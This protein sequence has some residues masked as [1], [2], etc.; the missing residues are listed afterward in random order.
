M[1]AKV[2]IAVGVYNGENY[3]AELLD[4][5]LAQTCADWECILVNDGSTDGSE[6]I[7]RG[8]AAKDTRFSVLSQPNAG[9]GAARNAAMKAGSSPYLMFADQDDRLAPNAV[10]RALAAIESTG[11]DIV[12]FHSNRTFRQSIF[13]WEHIFRRAAIAGVVFP[14]ITGG[15]D[16][17]FFWELGFRTLV[18]VEIPDVLY[19]Q[20]PHGGSFSRAVSPR[21]IANVFEGFR[22]MS[23]TA[24]RYGLPGWRTRLRLIPHVVPFTLSVIVR[25][26]SWAN[27]CA[28]GR[29]AVGRGARP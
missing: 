27:L 17:A 8:F 11:A 3:L 12:R 26:F 4:S 25:H 16:T 21:Y 19:W 24:R 15:E 18:R 13:V 20:R 9:V 7:L 29:A 28:L 2:S 22:V 1:A 5:I 23:R 14:P 6:A 10:E